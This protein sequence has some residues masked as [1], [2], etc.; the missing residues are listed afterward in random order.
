MTDQDAI[1]T[2]AGRGGAR[3][4]LSPGAKA[5]GGPDLRNIFY[6]LGLATLVVTTLTLAA[7]ILAPIALA[8]LI[9]FLI[10]A[11]AR[12]IQETPMV[13][14][15]IPEWLALT[16]ASVFTLGGIVMAG[17]LVIQNFSELGEGL[18]G[19]DVR[20]A[21]TIASVEAT[22]GVEFGFD[23]KAAIENF[24]ITDFLG[25]I[26]DVLS[27]TASNISVVLLFVLFLMFD[28]P[29]Y[30]AK[31]R[32]LF[33]DAGR[34]ERVRSVLAKIGQDTRTYVWLMT[35]V[36]VFVG[37]LTYLICAYFDL[38]GA[39]FWGFLAFALNFIPT[40]G[41][42]A[43]VV[44]PSAF[45]FVQFEDPQHTLLFIAALGVVQFTMGNILLPRLTGDRLNLSEF[46]VVLSLV[47]WGA[48]WGVAGMFLAVPLMMVLAIVL[49]QFD[50]TRAVAILLSKNGRVGR[51][52]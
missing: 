18:R 41:S 20:A 29:Y 1:A 50:S 22:F 9:W 37:V 21:E 6:I 11:I 26:V 31:I 36:S 4:G 46:V 19:F 38:K 51:M 5:A 7:D 16:V 40:I 34:R 27:T 13:G 17:R 33:P 24:R 28:Q 43:G 39:I 14:A 23:V 49:A 2:D 35:L 15:M 25:Q 10:N 44:F 52:R 12:G 47:I 3:E 48:M 32:A 8:I 30:S 45:A 42:F